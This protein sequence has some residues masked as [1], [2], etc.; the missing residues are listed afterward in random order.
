MRIVHIEAGR[1]L[2]GGAAQVRYLVEGLTRVGVDNVLVC[3]RG[4]A[5]AAAPPAATV[6]PL[7]MGGDLDV[8]LLPRLVRALRRL[9]PDLVHVH[10]RRGADVYGGLAAAYVGLPAVLTRRVDAA[11]PRWLAAPKYRP[12]DAV[13]ALSSAIAAQLRAS[14]VAPARVV[15]IPSAVDTRRFAPDAGA[16]ER[17]R[18]TFGL[19]RDALVVG[20]VAQLIERK[21]HSRLLAIV[22]DLVRALPAVHVVCFGRGPLERR[23]EAELRERGCAAHV[24]LA[25]FRDDLPAL[26]PGLDVLA[27]PADRE[28]LGLALLEAASAG[29]PV[30]ACAA[31]GIP[32][33]V[34]HER[35]GLLVP[36]DAGDALRNALLRLLCDSAERR[37]L[38]AA[39]RANAEQR[40]SVGGLVAEH[41]ALYRRVRD[42]RA[43]ARQALVS[44]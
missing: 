4:S 44:R 34:H 7:P 23:L 26:L 6:V 39:A 35:T 18:A 31:G 2:Y 25:G 12:Y 3:A 41:L 33:V 24:T 5:L 32:D 22:P 1:H 9:A 40:H 15:G 8:R 30:V 21:R 14:G 13:V 29:V 19:A 38:G 11:E 17:L 42:E 16:R 10:S 27:H 43:A 20:V 36:V 37:R 28:G